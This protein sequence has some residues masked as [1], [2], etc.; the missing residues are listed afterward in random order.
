VTG[1]GRTF[2]LRSS[3]GGCGEN[4][5]F[6]GKNDVIASLFSGVKN[7]PGEPFFGGG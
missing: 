2:P 6:G 3:S 1:D 4:R 7:R 5:K